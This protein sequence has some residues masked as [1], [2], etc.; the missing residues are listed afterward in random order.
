MKAETKEGNE[1]LSIIEAVEVLSMGAV[2]II[3]LNIRELE[4]KA[5]ELDRREKG[6]GWCVDGHTFE[7]DWFDKDGNREMVGKAHMWVDA[8]YCPVCGKKLKSEESGE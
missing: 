3:E 8:D 4:S 6:C 1:I 2:G 7:C 5:A